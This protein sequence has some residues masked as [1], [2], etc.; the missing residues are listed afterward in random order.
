MRQTIPY[1]RQNIDDK[2]ISSVLKVL[3]SDFLTQGP[4]VEVF[5]KKISKTVGVRFAT[6]CNSATSALHISCLALGFKKNDILWTVPNSFVASANCA[7]QIGGKVDFVDICPISYNIDIELLK[8]KLIKA[9]KKKK[10]P[11]IIV[12]VHFAGQPTIQDEIYKLSKKFKFK[13]I[14]DASHSLGAK[15]KKITVGSCKWSDITVFSL[16]PVKIITSG[17]GGVATTNKQDLHKNLQ[18]LKNH[19]ITKNK[20]MFIRKNAPGWHYEQHFLGLNFRMNEISAS[21]GI[22]QLKKLNSHV[23][24]RNKIATYYKKK[25]K[26]INLI[27][28]KINKSCRSTFHLFV[29]KIKSKRNKEIQLK[30]FN[31]LRE[32]KILVNVHY[33]PI[34]LQPYYKKLGFKK[35]DFKISENH[36]ESTLS[37]PIYPGLSKSNLDYTIKQIKLFF[38]INVK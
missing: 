4:L 7:K 25:I 20:K 17:E 36:A 6:A 9:Q 2:D 34:H 24:E 16:H 19:G 29:V 30:L 23:K 14:E 15:Y 10:L 31:Y 18:M 1:S 5:E 12:P 38:K 21:L 28:P 3:K 26:I 13:I 27:L 35:G 37:L 8:K 33:I 11:K 32:K 22:S